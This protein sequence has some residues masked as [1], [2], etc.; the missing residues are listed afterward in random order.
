M[1]SYA[2]KQEIPS[3]IEIDV[4]KDEIWAKMKKYANVDVTQKTSP[5]KSLKDAVNDRK[6]ELLQVLATGDEAYKKYVEQ[7]QKPE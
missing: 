2:A 5:V 7:L 3:M 4:N 1:K 6:M